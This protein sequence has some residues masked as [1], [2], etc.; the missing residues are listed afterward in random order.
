M[1][2]KSSQAKCFLILC[3]CCFVPT[4][5][6][7]ARL[8]RLSE[9]SG[10]LI[11][12]SQLTDEEL[13]S[14]DVL[15]RESH[16]RLLQGGIQMNTR[17]SIYHPNFLSF[18]ADVNLIGLSSKREFFSDS[19]LNNSL[20][21]T[22]D[23]QIS[24]LSKKPVSLE[25]YTRRNF[26]SADRDFLERYFQ[27][28][29]SSGLRILSKTNILPFTL[30]LYK[31]DLLSESEVFRERQEK[32]DNIDFKTTFLEKE[33]TKSDMT[34]RWKDY[35][36]AVYTIDYRSLDGMVNLLHSYGQKNRNRLSY[37][38]TFHKMTGDFDIQRFQ[39]RTSSLHY[40]DSPLYLDNAYTFIL[41][42]SFGRSFKRN[43]VQSSINHQLYQSL[44]SS[45]ELGGRQERSSLQDIF[46]FY[47]HV[48][49]NYRKS[50]PTGRIQVFLAN[51]FEST[52]FSSRDGLV[53][54][55]ELHN[56]SVSDTIVMTQPGIT[57]DLFQ[58]TSPD[59]SQLYLEG[60][61][62]LVER[63]NF[64]TS[65]IRLPGGSIPSGAE[66]MVHFM[67]LSFPDFRLKTHFYTVNMRLIFLKYL[68]VFY[69]RK[70]NQNAIRSDYLIPPYESY[71]QDLLGVRFD[72]RILNLE[73]FYEWRD[74][75]LADYV[76]SN[77]RASAALRLSRTINFSGNMIIRRLDYQPRIF[78]SRYNAYSF[79]G[80]YLP[81][82][83]LTLKLIYRDIRYATDLY[84]RKRKSSFF[85]LQW[86]IRKVIVIFFYEY[87]FNRHEGTKRFHDFISIMIR[88]TF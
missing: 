85:K 16:R 13:Y 70:S 83:N 18:S 15:S 46:G 77:I 56:F 57:M 8:F 31:T 12:L 5:A 51:R 52:K 39:F 14:S 47:S 44:N 2:T 10:S 4:Q 24:F 1:K 63:I 9:I 34:I 82:K 30:H 59:L 32:T 29:Q 25:L 81:H 27:T 66:V 79:E 6:Q 62:Y 43:R 28:F 86:T 22:Y 76:S 71:V 54:A 7:E 40:L 42:K 65:L 48:S 53:Q 37:F 64:S 26:S 50:I 36:E 33:K 67:Y 35:K 55:S 69:I 58:V 11:F 72:A 75:T 88:R 17:G 61:D 78:F 74:S 73:Y 41:D 87:I 60:I 20:N 80:S 38:M 21:N 49:L 23:F 3:F 68:D 84:Q 19:S 45:I